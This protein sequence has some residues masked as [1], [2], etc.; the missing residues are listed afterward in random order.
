MD[1][2]RLWDY[3]REQIKAMAHQV[4][5]VV[6]IAATE[7]HGPHLSVGVDSL[8]T[9]KIALEG[10]K[11]VATAQSR[12]V[13][14]PILTYGSS[15]HHLP[16]GGTLSLTSET[17]LRVL[18]D[19]GESAVQWGCQRIFFL[20]GH[21]G[22]EDISH[23]AVRDL[24][25]THDIIAGAAS[26]WT[27]AWD[28]LVADPDCRRVGPLPGHAGGFETSL[29]L[30]L[31]PDLIDHGRYTSQVHESAVFDPQHALARPVIN[32]YR[33]FLSMDGYTDDARQASAE[34]G[35]H[36]FEIIVDSFADFLFTFSMAEQD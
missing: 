26:Y 9:E 23:Q 14:A 33:S 2:I 12:I 16:L 36:L 7:Q 8:V 28:R 25:L 27:L 13:V 17:F 19:I 32:R 4:T 5:L 30:A 24:V 31:W 22:N 20:N 15:H 1:G 10:A 35:D 11:R 21:G 3:T 6:P 34:V 29:M 18:K